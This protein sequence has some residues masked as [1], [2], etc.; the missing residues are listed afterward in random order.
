MNKNQ[1]APRIQQWALTLSAYENEISYKAGQTNGNADGLS[2]LPLPVMPG[3]GPLPGETI[4]LTEH[5]EDIPVHSGHIK[6]WT[7]RDPVLSQVLRY[8]LEG[9]PKAVNSD[10]LTPYYTKRTKLSVKDGGILWGT[11]VIVPPQGR[12]KFLSELHAFS[13]P[14]L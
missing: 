14:E 11:R 9:W 3:S 10:E 4:L 13:F 2:R 8:T 1:A 5:L 12:S 7:K 6:G